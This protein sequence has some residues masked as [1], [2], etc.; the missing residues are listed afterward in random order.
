M[1]GVT[2]NLS[3]LKTRKE[4]GNLLNSLSLTGSAVEV[5]THKGHYALE[6]LNC[7]K[8]SMLYCVDPWSVPDGYEEQV[9]TLPYGTTTRDEDYEDC[10][11][12]LSLHKGRVTYM[13]EMSHSAISKFHDHSLDFVYLDGDHR[14]EQ[15]KRD[16]HLWF[17][18]V[19][20]GGILAGHDF[21]CPGEKT[22]S[23]GA[24]IQPV[25]IPFAMSRGLTINIIEDAGWPTS[26]FIHIGANN[27]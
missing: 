18:K 14:Q 23:W 26:Y 13:R 15:F 6:F 27:D 9:P 3:P 22:G 5:G 25:L 20:K 7:W 24:Q 8:G 10:Q 11:N 1:I 4:L 12:R 19:K 17:P 21:T 2:I 16:L